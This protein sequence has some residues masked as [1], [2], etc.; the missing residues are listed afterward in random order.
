MAYHLDK[1]KEPTEEA[2]KEARIVINTIEQAKIDALQAKASTL[3]E[4]NSSLKEA[5]KTAKMLTEKNYPS[6]FVEPVDEYTS[7]LGSAR[8]LAQSRH[9]RAWARTITQKSL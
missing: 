1:E 9:R 3:A 8:I 6:M 5:Y 7:Q 4:E 2:K